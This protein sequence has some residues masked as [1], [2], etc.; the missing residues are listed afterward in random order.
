MTIVETVLTKK[1]HLA[2]CRGNESLTCI[3]QKTAMRKELI[4]NVV[5]S[6]LLFTVRKYDSLTEIIFNNLT[7]INVNVR[8]R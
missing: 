1:T 5:Q 7:E 2:K 8:G 6:P 4:G 3:M